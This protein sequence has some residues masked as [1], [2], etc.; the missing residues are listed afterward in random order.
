MLCESCVEFWVSIFRLD[1][2][3]PSHDCVTLM[4]CSRSPAVDKYLHKE[5]KEK[6]VYS[7]FFNA[8]RECGTAGALV[9]HQFNIHFF[10]CGSAGL[11]EH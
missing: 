5:T 4:L 1:S 3:I 7:S 2:R 8:L 9:L 10:H 6:C 11:R